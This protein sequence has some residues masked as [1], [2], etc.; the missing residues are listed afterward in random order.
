MK[1][2]KAATSAQRVARLIAG[3]LDGLEGVE[4]K[5]NALVVL[6]AGGAVVPPGSLD[7][8]F[9]RIALIGTAADPLKKE[10]EPLL[11]EPPPEEVPPVAS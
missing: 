1:K 5:I 2:K 11:P 9:G 6:V 4:E 3:L 8:I 7:K 10:P